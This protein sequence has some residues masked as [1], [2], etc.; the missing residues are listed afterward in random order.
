MKYKGL[1]IIACFAALALFSCEELANLEKPE[2]PEQPVETPEQGKSYERDLMLGGYAQDT[3]LTLREFKSAIKSVTENADWLEVSS[4][5]DTA[6]NTYQIRLACSENTSD[7]VRSTQVVV[8]S[9]NKDTLN[10]NV[11]QNVIVGKSFVRDMVLEGYA[12]DTIISIDEFTSGIALISN[13][14]DWLEVTSESDSISN[15]YQIRMVCSE[16][17]TDH[18]RSA[19]VVIVCQNRDTLNLSI[20]QNIFVGKSYV[21]ELTFDGYEQDTI[22]SIDEFTS[23]IAQIS[24]NADWLDVT[25]TSDTTSNTYQIIVVCSEN[26]TDQAR[27]TSVVIVSQN[28]DTLHLNISQKVFVGKSFVRELAF[29][30]YE[31][32]TILSIDEFTS[33][34]DE[35]TN[36]ADWV[37]VQSLKDS[38]PGLVQLEVLCSKNTTTAVR[39]SD[40]VL[41]SHR[42]TLTLKVNQD[43][44]KG[45]DDVHDNVTD[46]PALAP[47]R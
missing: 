26:F 17:L 25:S 10:I 14:A 42:D 44:L 22:I 8:I 30:G 35:V 43:I 15:T 3:T 4:T 9:E 16:N 32:D 23:G 40:V 39:S 18:V 27:S 19:S 47:G 11:S 45:F 7:Q 5:S 33:V 24:N 1:Y 36:D 2:Q 6:S 38:I 31:Q 13:D 28:W 20:C 37:K 29:D 46:Q 41:I 34:I 12:Q 21:R